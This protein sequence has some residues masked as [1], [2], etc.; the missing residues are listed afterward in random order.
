[1]EAVAARLAG[2]PDRP[3]ESIALVIGSFLAAEGNKK[4]RSTFAADVR[5]WRAE[6][7]AFDKL[8]STAAASTVSISSILERL[9]SG[10]GDLPE[11][12]Q[13]FLLVWGRTKSLLRAIAEVDLPDGTP[14]TVTY[15]NRR[16]LPGAKD[17]DP[18]FAAAA[19][20]VEA[21]FV[22]EASD[23][24]WR[25]LDLA[26]EQ[27]E[28][29]GDAR[30]ALWGQLEVLSRR[31]QRQGWQKSERRDI[32]GTVKHDHQHTLQL[33]AAAAGEVNRRLSFAREVRLLPE[34]V[35]E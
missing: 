17:F 22:A 23:R 21:I 28:L 11:W 12:Q 29:S 31:G 15:V 8:C 4:D 5:R 27:A 1:M 30:T 19:E 16:I 24:I 33:A 9:L 7:P 10:F 13:R 35:G 25:E 14:L 26:H 20:E 2:T 3:G 6:S 18:A 34:A 32:S